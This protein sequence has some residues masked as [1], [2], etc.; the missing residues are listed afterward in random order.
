M[1]GVVLVFRDVT[2]QR[3]AESMLHARQTELQT[4]VSGT[5]FMLT[6]CSRDLRYRFVSQAYAGMLGCQPRDVAG[7]AIVEI[8]GDEGFNAI[9]P[10]VE[11]VLRGERVSYESE[12]PFKN[13]GTR[14][15]HVSYTPDRDERGDVIGWIASI[16]DLTERRQTE[17][18]LR[19][20]EARF[21]DLVEPPPSAS[22][23][24]ILSSASPT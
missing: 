10:Y 19:G 12:V 20:S 7:K 24:W 2:A 8:M 13:V 21:S 1:T 16:V 14:T 17:Q 4:I 22:T 23:S 5:P 15:L 6:R 18:A 11:K 3:A 9:R